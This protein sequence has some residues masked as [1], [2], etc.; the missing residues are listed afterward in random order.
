MEW[1]NTVRT[2]L[3]AGII[4][5]D[6]YLAVYNKGHLENKEDMV[7]IA[8]HN[9]PDAEHPDSKIQGFHDVIQMKFWDTE[10]GWHDSYPPISEEQGKEI[11]EFIEKHKDKQF[12]IHCSAGMSRSAG[13]GRAVECIVNYDGNIYNYKIG[14]S[15]IMKNP[16]Y[17]PNKTVFDRILS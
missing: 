15:D 11:R 14:D 7:L 9:P 10:E 6:E 1:I 4:G 13:V 12:L 17:T 5:W 2:K 16:R 8:I 3:F